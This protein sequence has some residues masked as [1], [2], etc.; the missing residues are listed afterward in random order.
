VVTRGRL[1]CRHLRTKIE[2]Y[3]VRED[4]D[5]GGQPAYFGR[6]PTISLLARFGSLLDAQI[7]PDNA[8]PKLP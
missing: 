6:F 5:L 4:E 8:V 2:A 7:F 3:Y 1:A